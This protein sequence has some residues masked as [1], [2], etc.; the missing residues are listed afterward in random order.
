MQNNDSKVYNSYNF[1]KQPK[2]A[3]FRKVIAEIIWLNQ[4][5]YPTK[6][7]KL[8]NTTDSVQYVHDHY[9]LSIFTSI[10]G[11]KNIFYLHLNEIY[12]N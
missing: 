8:N 7:F 2:R 3:F 10:N 9:L 12:L 6:L 4:C 11:A 1:H 5:F